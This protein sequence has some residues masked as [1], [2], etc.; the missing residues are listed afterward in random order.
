MRKFS[1]IRTQVFVF[2]IILCFL[3]AGCATL[4]Q[5][6]G[7]LTPN[8]KARIIIGDIQGQLDNL[9]IIGKDYVT[10]NPKYQDKWKKEIVPAFSVANQSLASIILLGKTK[11]LTPEFVYTTIQNNVTIICNL[12]IQ[13]G[14]IK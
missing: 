9:F 7:A 2:S 4:Q 3:L 6:W 14:A 1:K 11:P 10:T 8:E 12:L 5:K 13:I